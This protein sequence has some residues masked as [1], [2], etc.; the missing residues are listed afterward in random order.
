VDNATIERFH[1][2]SSTSKVWGLGIGDAELDQAFLELDAETKNMSKD[3]R[4]Q[5]E[6]ALDGTWKETTIEKFNRRFEARLTACREGGPCAKNADKL[7]RSS[8]TSR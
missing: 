5:V 8:P 6:I 4:S 2:S 1:R 7:V 3:Q